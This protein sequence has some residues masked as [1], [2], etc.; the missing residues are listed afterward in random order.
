MSVI[1]EYAWEFKGKQYSI[2]FDLSDATYQ[3]YGLRPNR[4]NPTQKLEDYYERIISPNDNDKTMLM[5][6]AQLMTKAGLNGMDSFD[7]KLEFIVGFVQNAI[8]TDDSKAQEAIIAGTGRPNCPYETL[9]SKK[10][11]CIDK[12]LLL[13][14]LI[15]NTGYYGSCLLYYP[16][17]FGKVPHTAVGIQC[18]IGYSLYNSGFCYAETM[19]ELPIG[20][21]P[22]VNN[23]GVLEKSI[24][25]GLFTGC[26][27]NFGKVKTLL[28]MD[29]TKEYVPCKR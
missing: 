20:L 7:E 14:A 6:T 10:G 8:K 29:G 3:Q 15:R 2:Q 4:H 27:T 23:N 22:K 12:S 1:K 13:I 17:A 5:V 9:Y 28:I 19:M 18:P 24:S 26:H 16:N 21:M 25:T 11:I